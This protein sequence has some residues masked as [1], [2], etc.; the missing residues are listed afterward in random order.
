MSKKIWIDMTTGPHVLFFE[1]LI[2]T[3]K[4]E[5]AE[6]LI[7]ARPYQQTIELLDQRKLNYKIIGKHYGKNKLRKAFGLFLQVFSSLERDNETKKSDIVFN[8]S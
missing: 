4:K 5:G 8:Y 2:K 3:L 1:P 7:T 6:F